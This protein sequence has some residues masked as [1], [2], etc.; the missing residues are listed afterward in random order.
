MLRKRC[1]APLALALE[2][3]AWVKFQRAVQYVAP[4][5]KIASG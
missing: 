1:K 2:A 3:L 4:N 5:R